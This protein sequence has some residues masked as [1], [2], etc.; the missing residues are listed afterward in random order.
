MQHIPGAGFFPAQ[1][2]IAE[3]PLHRAEQN[4]ISPRG[5]P[6][7]VCCTP[8]PI[9]GSRK[10]RHWLFDATCGFTHCTSLTL[11]SKKHLSVFEMPA[12]I[13]QH[14][15][16]QQGC[17]WGPP[18]GGLGVGFAGVLLW[19]TGVLTPSCSYRGHRHC[20]PMPEPCCPLAWPPRQRLSCSLTSVTFKA[21]HPQ[22]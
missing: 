5:H 2:R 13:S 7:Q 17:K 4:S 22:H 11:I 14:A 21:T 1:P 16:A 8:R 15:L 3:R 20:A 18:R 6:Q 9:C 10:Q 12:L 19:G